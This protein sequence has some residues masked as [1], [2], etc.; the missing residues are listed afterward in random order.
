MAIKPSNVLLPIGLPT[1]NELRCALATIVRSIQSAHHLTDEALSDVLGVS[2]GTIANVRNER[3]DLNQETIARIGK[4]FGPE[5]LDPWS[6]C[7]GGRNVPR[8]A[9]NWV[10]ALHDITGLAHKLAR[11]IAPDSEAREAI[12]HTELREMLPELKA[13]QRLINRLLARAEG[14]G[15][16]A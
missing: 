16:V 3:T 6:A 11:A 1:R 15:M 12:S 7:F 5:T 10:V 2:A 14:L 8:D 13:S 9:D 4:Q